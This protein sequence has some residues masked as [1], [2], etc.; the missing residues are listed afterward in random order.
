MTDT[1]FLPENY[2]VPST[3]NYMK[4][5]EGENRFRILGSS[6]IGYEYWKTQADNSRKP[7][8][9]KMGIPIPVEELEEN[10]KTGEIEIPKHFWIFPVWN[11]DAKKVQLLEVTQKTIQRAIRGYVKN[12]KW[13]NPKDY[14]I[15]V[16]RIKNGTKT[17]YTVSTNPKEPVSEDILKAYEL[18]T[19][20]LDA[21][22]EGKDP[23]KKEV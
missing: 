19:I 6:I 9:V 2:E 13:G 20:N 16:T 11:Y 10:P 8:R 4:F 18:V 17:E 21:L 14:D 1:N 3:S 7:V 15:I 5:E 23:F 12:K 22:Y